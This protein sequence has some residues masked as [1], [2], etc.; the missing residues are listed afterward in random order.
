VHINTAPLISATDSTHT[1]TRVRSQSGS[2]IASKYT[3]TS[4]RTK[5]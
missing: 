5:H 4:Q 3:P 1:H 2:A